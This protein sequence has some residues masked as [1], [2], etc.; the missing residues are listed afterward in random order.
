MGKL[1]ILGDYLNANRRT[2]TDVTVEMANHD[3]NDQRQ[4]YNLT[5]Y[6][7]IEDQSIP[8]QSVSSAALEAE[9]HKRHTDLCI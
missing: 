7:E 9:H 3:K 5:W 1:K 2:G 8:F 6:M 4:F